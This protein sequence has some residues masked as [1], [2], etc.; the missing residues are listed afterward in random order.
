MK[1]VKLN[2]LFPDLIRHSNIR[3]FLMRARLGLKDKSMELFYLTNLQI[4]LKT[5]WTH[6]LV[7]QAVDDEGIPDSR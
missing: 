1:P 3:E 2:K 6:N 4:I 5:L 7:S